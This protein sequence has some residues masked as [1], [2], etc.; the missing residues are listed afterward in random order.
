MENEKK[1]EKLFYK[2]LLKDI[3]KAR[4]ECSLVFSD[5]F[6]KSLVDEV[7]FEI[8]HRTDCIESLSH[9]SYYVSFINWLIGYII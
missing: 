8:I 4:K 9:F 7:A 1:H 5:D 3:I 6:F 2:Q